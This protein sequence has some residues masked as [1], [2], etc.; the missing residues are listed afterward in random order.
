MDKA[1][2]PAALALALAVVTDNTCPLRQCRIT[3]EADLFDTLGMD[4]LDRMSL[5]MTLEEQRQIEIPDDDVAEW[6]T[7]RDIA[8]TLDRL[9][10]QHLYNAVL[11]DWPDAP[12]PKGEAA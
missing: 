8:L 10:G 11:A 5:A 6:R 12:L 9:T 7:P 3:P 1:P 2:S 4:S